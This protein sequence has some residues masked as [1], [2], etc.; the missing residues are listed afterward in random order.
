[1]DGE[2][3]RERLRTGRPCVFLDRDGVLTVPEFRGG[4]SYAPRRLADFAVY[5]EA[6]GALEQL[7]R[8]GFALVVVTNQPDI[9]AGRVAAETV[10][11]MHER[12][13]DALPLEILGPMSQR[14]R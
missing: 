9:G 3:G 5:P 12:L 7:R 1:M 4:R 11:R 14:E 13:A 8:A 2:S 10:A 6:R